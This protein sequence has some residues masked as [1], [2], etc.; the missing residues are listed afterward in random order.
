MVGSACVESLHFEDVSYILHIV[1][2]HSDWFRDELLGMLCS[3]HFI[4]VHFTIIYHELAYAGMSLKE[5]KKIV[6]ERN[7]SQ[8]A[9]FIQ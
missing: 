2:H 6:K 7:V 9:N 5:L 3:N 1:N 4:S 8:C